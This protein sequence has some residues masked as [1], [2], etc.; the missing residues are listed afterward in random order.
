MK[1]KASG[2][3]GVKMIKPR[4]L[5]KLFLFAALIFSA[6]GLACRSSENNAVN[7][8]SA[9]PTPE[10]K[11]DEFQDAFNS[12]KV[13]GF[14]YIFVFRRP[15]GA[16]MTGE[17]KTFLKENSSPFTNRWNLTDDGKTVI[18]GSNYKFTPEN[19]EALKKRF[20]VEDH[21]VVKLD[22][23]GSADNKNGNRN[24]K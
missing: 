11:R 20:I 24:A 8:N 6:S 14:D 1:K 22:A 3:N 18:A 17:D 12:V 7:L 4:Y 19:M 10:K 13:G 16:Q 23:A 21:S 15:D 2:K 9:T 5:T